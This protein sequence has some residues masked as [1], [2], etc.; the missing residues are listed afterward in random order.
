MFSKTIRV[1]INEKTLKNACLELVTMNGRPFKLMDDSGFRKILNP[2]LEDMRANFNIN[3]D[4]IREKIEVKADDVNYCMKLEVGHK[5]VSL[6]ADVATCRNRSIHGVNLQFISD[7]K[8]QLR[9]LA[10]KELKNNHTGLYLKT[11][12][13]KVIEQYKPTMAPTC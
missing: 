3:A 10:M 13:D 9:T 2:F 1:K 6:K 12:L 11:V 8:V 4:N 7:G 5:L